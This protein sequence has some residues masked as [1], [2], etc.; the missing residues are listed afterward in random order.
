MGMPWDAW[1]ATAKQVPRRALC[2]MLRDQQ[3]T[4]LTLVGRLCRDAVSKIKNHCKMQLMADSSDA[5]VMPN[6]FVQ[7]VFQLKKHDWQDAN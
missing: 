1:I 2:K 7:A 4:V 6:T 5:R 3:G